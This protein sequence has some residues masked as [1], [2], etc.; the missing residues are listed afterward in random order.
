MQRQW[1]LVS[2]A[3][4]ALITGSMLTGVVMTLPH[5]VRS[6]DAYAQ[7]VSAAEDAQESLQA[8]QNLSSAFRN[9]S[10]ALRPSVVSTDRKSV[11]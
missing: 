2:V 6:S 11:V 8:A 1:K 7:Q 5:G 4:A 10:D 9:V 3:C